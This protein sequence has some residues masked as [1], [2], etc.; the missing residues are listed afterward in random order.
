MAF[1][2]N[3]T[4]QGGTVPEGSASTANPVVV[5][6]IY[7]STPPTLATGQVA[8]LQQDASGNVKTV[9]QNGITAGTAGSPSSNVITFQGIT[10]GTPAP[11]QPSTGTGGGASTYNVIAPTTPVAVDVNAGAGK[12]WSVHCTNIGAVMAYLH[13]YDVSA[14][15]SLGS[16]AATWTLPIPFNSQ[17]GGFTITYPV[18][19]KVANN[20]YVAITAGIAPTDNTPLPTANTVLVDMTY[21]A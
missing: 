20:L 6:G 15:P 8:R 10:G 2:G 3:V 11:V 17:G 21:S 19:R 18:G 1:F 4:V 14:A 13:V 7:E 16:T 5:G 9:V 12:V